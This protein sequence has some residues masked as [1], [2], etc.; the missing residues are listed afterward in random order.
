MIRRR[1]DDTSDPLAAIAM[2]QGFYARVAARLG[3]HQSFVGR[4]AHGQR[5][6]PEVTAVLRCELGVIRDH[7]NR[8]NRQIERYMGPKMC[9]R[10]EIPGALPEN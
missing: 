7:L 4:V 2:F 8:T 1:V 6:S 3:V 9:R 10:P 5:E